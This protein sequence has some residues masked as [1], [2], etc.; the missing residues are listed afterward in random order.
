[1][2]PFLKQV[3]QHYF[4]GG[5]G[6]I[7]F[8]FPNRRAGKFFG[9]YLTEEI[10]GRQRPVRLPE[11][12]TIN[13]FFAK[14]SG[15]RAADRITLLVELYDCYKALYPKA[16]S[17][18]DFIFWGDT[19]L[20]DFN[21]V[22]KY[23]VNAKDLF[24]NVS[25]FKSI[26]DDFSHLNQSQRE[27]IEA[28]LSHFDPT[29]RKEG[30][31]EEFR[32]IWNILYPLYLSFNKRLSDKGL[33]Y[34]GMVY[35][36][37][38][39]E[40]S[41]GSCK[42]KLSEKFPHTDTFVFVGL[43]ALN[44][45]E[46][47]V[48]DAMRNASAAQ[49]CWDFSGEM[50]RNP[51]NKSSFFMSDNIVRYPQAFPLDPEGLKLPEVNVVSVPSSVGQT[52]QVSGILGDDDPSS[53]AVVLGDETLLMPLLNSLDDK[54]REVN[55]TMGYPMASSEFFAFCRILHQ[56]QL[57][58]RPKG[59]YYKHV[60]ALFSSGIFRELICGNEKALQKIDQIR[61]AR[62]YYI[63]YEDFLGGGLPE[64][65]FRQAVPSDLQ[66]EEAVAAL[67][68]YLCEVAEYVGERLCDE[69]EIQPD[70]DL[71][72]K[73]SDYTLEVDL[74]KEY[75]TCINRLLSRNLEV[76]L[77]TFVR[78]AEQLLS[79]VS[80]A[81]NGEPL[82]GLQIMGPLETRALDFSKLIILSANEGVFP[83]KSIRAS[84]IPP[85]LRK[86]FGLPTYEYQ[87]AVWAYYFYRMISRAQSVWLLYDSRTEGVIS[88]EESRYV[89]QLRYHF[90][91]PIHNWVASAPIAMPPVRQNAITKTEEDVAL[92]ASR[93]LSASSLKS[94]IDCP[95][96]FYYKKVKNL[97]KEEEVA[98]SLD[99]GLFG[100]VYHGAMYALLAGEQQMERWGNIDKR[101]KPK[102]IVEQRFVTKEYL[103]DYLARE[104]KIRWKV[105]SLICDELHCDEVA[106]RNLVF[107]DL[108]VNLVRK[109]IEEDIKMMDKAGVTKFEV[110]GLELQVDGDI[111]D[112]PFTGDID[113]VDSLGAGNIRLVDYKTGKDDPSALLSE[114]E[115]MDKVIASIFDADKAEHEKNKAVLQFYIYD[116]LYSQ[117]F[118][119]PQTEL[120]NSMYS[121]V[122][123]GVLSPESNSFSSDFFA[124]MDECVSELLA[125]MRNVDEPFTKTADLRKC[126]RCDFRT[127]CGR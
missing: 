46:K 34:E 6:N 78:L 117:R 95:V 109:T 81:F 112:Q 44:E 47:K 53:C 106:G 76:K 90:R 16:E 98:E 65:I 32:R 105:N 104:D 108:I 115:K 4:G 60:W 119:V 40:F 49:F 12:V 118:K 103:K 123:M 120:L 20:G 101:N 15:C 71:P 79:G 27:A 94:Y 38:A 125:Q 30:V 80:V 50:I 75:Y 10:A 55:V 24:T 116:K 19:L 31:K 42:E 91:L 51:L 67:G 43:N 45:C 70:D 124:V 83:R 84:F 41:N 92:I 73:N 97:G 57:T 102:D 29:Q 77:P 28:F 21:D 1:M 14:A 64:L 22:D 59:L 37:L 127:L 9:K 23:R 87:D 121:T 56:L 69:M 68:A 35:R 113:R 63:P 52:K 107:A 62:K 5:L 11:I 39:D 3:A 93:K 25:D 111:F 61:K 96:Q 66:G 89:K 17:L 86:G 8:V 2:V 100:N 114:D 33:A 7:C 72:T 26:S 54:V 18:D 58:A 36:A 85:E 48:L 82:K 110:L 126:E 13:D 74:A 99:A 88:G 122:K